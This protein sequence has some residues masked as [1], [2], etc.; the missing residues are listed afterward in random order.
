MAELVDDI[1]DVLMPRKTGRLRVAYVQDDMHGC[2]SLAGDR[3]SVAMHE[4]H[5]GH[6]VRDAYMD[7]GD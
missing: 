7:I 5:G 1:Q 6:D 3:M 4:C 2:I